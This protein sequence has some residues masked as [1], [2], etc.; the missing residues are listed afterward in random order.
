MHR[1]ILAGLV[2]SRKILFIREEKFS[3]QTNY[4]DAMAHEK[5]H[6]VSIEQVL[7][8]QA[9]YKSG[10]TGTLSL[11]VMN[12]LKTWLIN[13]IQGCE[14]NTVRTSIARESIGSPDTI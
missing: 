9:K 11:G 10:A 7:E 1:K 6:Q 14:Q 3:S 12:F 4:P 2:D 13:H 8:V 5:E